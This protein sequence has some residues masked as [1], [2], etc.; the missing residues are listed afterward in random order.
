M[1]ED[2]DDDFEP[3]WLNPANDRKTPYTEKEIDI[4]V[5]GFIT[6]LDH[7]EW[8]AYKEKY[9][10]E[11]KVRQI[12]RAGIISRDERNLINLTPKDTKH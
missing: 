10:G 7:H 2:S 12:I 4:F 5:E 1:S 8:M 9:G 3:E 6:G 11:E